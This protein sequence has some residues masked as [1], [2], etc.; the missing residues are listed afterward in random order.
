MDSRVA[1]WLPDST[2]QL[3]D[4]T[5]AFSLDPRRASGGGMG[6]FPQPVGRTGHRDLARQQGGLPA[7]GWV[8]WHG[9][10]PG[11]FAGQRFSLDLSRAAAPAETLA[12]Q[13]ALAIERANLADE[14][15]KAKVQIETERTRNALLSSIS[16]DLKTPLAAITGAATSLIEI[17]RANVTSSRRRLPKKRTA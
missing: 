12:N 5:A 8:A 1:I 15:Q 10:L 7:L 4:A 2:G 17:P 3:T 11:C 13:I 6:F 14:S 16:H 9:R